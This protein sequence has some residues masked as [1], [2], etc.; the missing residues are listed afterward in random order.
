MVRIR[1]YPLSLLCLLRVTLTGFSAYR[2]AQR[3]GIAELQATGL[4][5]LD[6]YASS[7]EREI[8]K[9]AFLPRMLNLAPDVIELLAAKP[10]GGARVNVYLERLNEL[11]GRLSI[12][13]MDT[14]GRVLASSTW[15]P[16]DFHKPL[17]PDP[18]RCTQGIAFT[19]RKAPRI[20]QSEPVE[21]NRLG[22]WRRRHPQP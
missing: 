12:F 18:G 13:V 6:L 11:A 1:S 3:L 7:V 15:R 10:G 5:R 9:Y 19:E 22:R 8:R 4:H 20:L 21:G 14:R 16:T 17:R 2:I